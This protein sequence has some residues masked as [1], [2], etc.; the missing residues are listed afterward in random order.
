M[1]RCRRHRSPCAHPRCVPVH[2]QLKLGRCLLSPAG[3]MSERLLDAILD[4]AVQD[5]V[6]S[7]NLLNALLHDACKSGLLTQSLLDAVLHVLGDELFDLS[8]RGAPCRR[9]SGAVRGRGMRLRESLCDEGLQ[10][11]VLVLVPLGDARDL[12]SEPLLQDL[13]HTP[14]VPAAALRLPSRYHLENGQLLRGLGLPPLLLALLPHG[15]EP[16]LVMHNFRIHSRNRCRRL[17]KTGLVLGHL[18]QALMPLLPNRLHDALDVQQGP[19]GALDLP[20]GMHFHGEGIQLVPEPLEVP[21]ETPDLRGHRQCCRCALVTA[22]ANLGNGGRICGS[23]GRVGGQG[24]HLLAQSD[25][26]LV[27]HMY[28][29]PQRLDLLPLRSLAPCTR[30]C[31]SE[32]RAVRRR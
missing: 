1:Q 21:G 22:H 28:R 15:R 32:G 24:R 31:D 25:H 10:L 17:P 6:A 14:E 9:R 29:V 13:E 23:G 16:F 4:K 18:G 30:C 8:S 5:G 26:V 2:R 12:V 20:P 7:Q 19:C 3:L 11:L 27:H